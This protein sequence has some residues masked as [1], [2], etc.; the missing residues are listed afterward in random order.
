MNVNAILAAGSNASSQ[1]PATGSAKTDSNMFMTLLVA[2]LKNQDPLQPQDGA[3]FVAQL[4]QF[5]SL[6]NL[7]GIRQAMEQLLASINQPTTS[8]PAPA[9]TDPGSTIDSLI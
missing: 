8:T 9:T 3:A 1:S 6:D 2:Q 5:N 4:A 7:I